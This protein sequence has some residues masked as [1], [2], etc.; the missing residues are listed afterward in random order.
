MKKILI[1]TLAVLTLALSG[2][3]SSA[4]T[5]P[6]NSEIT[7]VIDV[8]TAAEYASGH[9]SNAINIDVEDSSFSS[10]ISNL[11]KSGVY[12]VYC[13]SGRRSALAATALT[14]AGYTVVDGGGI[15]SMLSNGWE[16]GQ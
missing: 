5:S 15:D 7:Q 4:D 2:C 8:R 3:A 6:N 11:N 13:Q 9:V 12:L 1:S 16:L 14:E 10:N